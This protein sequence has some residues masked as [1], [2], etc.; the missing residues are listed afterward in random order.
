MTTLALCPYCSK[1][2]SRQAVQCTSCGHPVKKT[3]D[4][5]QMIKMIIYTVIFVAFLL[6]LLKITDFDIFAFIKSSIFHVK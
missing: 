3:L 4:D 6:F 1:E 2:V 5:R